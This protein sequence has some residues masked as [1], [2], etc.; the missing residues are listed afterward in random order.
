MWSKICAA[1][2]FSVSLCA[3][4]YAC[5]YVCVCVQ[6][7]M[8]K[9]W[10]T[11]KVFTLLFIYTNGY[12]LWLKLYGKMEFSTKEHAIQREWK[13]WIEIDESDKESE[14]S[15]M[16]LS[17]HSIT[18]AILRSIKQRRNVRL[19][20][21]SSLIRHTYTKYSNKYIYI[22]SFHLAKTHLFCHYSYKLAHIVCSNTYTFAIWELVVAAMAVGCGF[23][24]CHDAFGMIICCT[25][26]IWWP[27]LIFVIIFRMFG[28][29]V[30]FWLNIF[31]IY[32]WRR[33]HH[34]A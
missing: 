27:I 26:R 4:P 17:I 19:I 33:T 31:V 7:N 6:L 24:N 28:F 12:V 9:G 16:K 20:T 1:F 8:E 15:S 3:S 13:K 10:N 34:E 32:V 11:N 30:T 2:S 25:K 5:L 22:D 21:V 29:C 23:N 18:Y 14:I